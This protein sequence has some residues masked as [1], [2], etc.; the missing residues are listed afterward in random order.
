MDVEG[1][2][3]AFMDSCNVSRQHFRQVF[4]PPYDMEFVSRRLQT[5]VSKSILMVL[6]GKVRFDPDERRS[7]RAI[8]VYT[9]D[10]TPLQGVPRHQAQP[11]YALRMTRLGPKLYPV[12]LDLT[13]LHPPRH[14]SRH[15]HHP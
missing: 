12:G 1:A 5:A 10:G 13:K 8:M 4:V 15:G 3:G 14:A 6:E 9:P 11:E 7:G 2:L